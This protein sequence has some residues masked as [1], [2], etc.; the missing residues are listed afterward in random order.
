VPPGFAH[1]FVALEDDTVFS[2]KC[3]N[4]YNKES[5]RCIIW[6]DEDLNI[7]WQIKSPILSLK[8]TMGIS[9]KDFESPF[10]L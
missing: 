6:N 5:E 1:G 10:I 4:V 8:D 2:Y 3:T 7:D 9:F